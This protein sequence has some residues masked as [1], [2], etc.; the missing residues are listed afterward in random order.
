MDATLSVDQVVQEWGNALA[1]RIPAPV[2]NA[3]HFWPGLP[4]KVKVVDGGVFLR[5]IRRPKL[6]LAQKL[7][8]FDPT[9]HGGEIAASRRIG[10]E[11]F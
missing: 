1:V 5:A 6:T 2:A 9:V 4:I 7:K 10:G 11:M 8:A 3:A